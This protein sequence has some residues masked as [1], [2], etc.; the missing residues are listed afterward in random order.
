MLKRA[1]SNAHSLY[2]LQGF[3]QLL[4]TNQLNLTTS[5]FYLHAWRNQNNSF[6]FD[7]G[8]KSVKESFKDL[9]IYLDDI[10]HACIE[11]KYT[12]GKQFY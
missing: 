2:S 1:L 6:A 12:E 10:N 8:Y 5:G 11:A 7:G 3:I 9:K 4:K